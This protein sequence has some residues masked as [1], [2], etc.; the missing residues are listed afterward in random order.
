MAKWGGPTPGKRPPVRKFLYLQCDCEDF[1]I[2]GPPKG[3]SP[4]GFV[5]RYVN[6]RKVYVAKVTDFLIPAEMS[7]NRE[8]GRCAWRNDLGQYGFWTMTKSNPNRVHKVLVTLDG[9]YATE[10]VCKHCISVARF[11][12]RRMWNARHLFVHLAGDPRVKKQIKWH[13]Y[14]AGDD[15]REPRKMWLTRH[16]C[17]TGWGHY[18]YGSRLFGQKGEVE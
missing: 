16:V 15:W 17:A 1:T 10:W 3:F 12:G 8:V 6:A 9:G 13:K 2:Y 4:E 18:D 14:L 5:S 7:N 11:I